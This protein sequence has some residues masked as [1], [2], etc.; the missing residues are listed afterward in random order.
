ME[1]GKSKKIM[2]KAE[3]KNPCSMTVDKPALKHLFLS[4][5]V[6]YTSER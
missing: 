6:L 5:F 1:N 3:N 2:Q 4:R